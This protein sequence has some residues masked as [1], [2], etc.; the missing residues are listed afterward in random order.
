M[1]K[2][3]N[4]YWKWRFIVII[5]LLAILIAILCSCNP[6][7]QAARKDKKY[8]DY[9]NASVKRQEPVV[10]E[11]INA[12]PDRI[13]STTDLSAPKEIKVNVPI[14]VRDTARER[15]IKDSMLAAF[16]KDTTKKNCATP[17]IEAFDLGYEQAEKYYLSHPVKAE[18]PPDTTRRYANQFDADRYKDSLNQ[19]KLL[20]AGAN[21]IIGEKNTSIGVANKRGDHWEMWS[22]L[23]IGIGLILL[24]VSHIIRSY[25]SSW[26]K[27]S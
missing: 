2:N 1:F 17:A 13:K 9:V 25:F 19:A 16:A 18:C 5:A 24:I 10:N 22:Y 27:K 26:F 7:K 12:H 21:G 6:E 3:I 23:W 4:P 8:I 20:L 14:L 11:Y 15:I